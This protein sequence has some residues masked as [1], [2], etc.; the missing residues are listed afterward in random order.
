MI[1]ALI[2]GERDPAVLAGM[3]LGKMRS[4]IPALTEALVGRFPAH[5]GVVARAILDHIDVPG[6]WG[7]NLA[8]RGEI[9]EPRAGP[10]LSALEPVGRGFLGRCFWRLII[11]PR[12]KTG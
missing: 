8:P 10:E 6:C 3:A 5:H 9:A 2:A 4:K 11:R 7:A 12:A 1:E